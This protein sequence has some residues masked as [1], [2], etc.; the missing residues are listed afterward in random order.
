MSSF[1]LGY[2]KNSIPGSFNV[3]ENNLLGYDGYSKY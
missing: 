3:Y 2:H 1:T